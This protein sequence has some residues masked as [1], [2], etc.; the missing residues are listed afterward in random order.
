M[1]TLNKPIKL[2]VLA[3]VAHPDD[4]E[5][6][7]G[8]L[9]IKLSSNKRRVGI[10]DLSYGEMGTLGSKEERAREAL[11][12]AHILGL[13]FRGNL[14]LPDAAIEYNHQNSYR[15]AEQIRFLKPKLVIL[16]HWQ[17]RHPDHLAASKIGY[18]ACFFAGLK[19]LPIKGDAFRPE[20]IIYASY[21]QSHDY[22]F[23]V[24]I[25][26]FIR[27]K[28]KAIACY[29]TQ[30]GNFENYKEL[31]YVQGKKIFDLLRIRAA[32]FGSRVG[33]EFAEAYSIHEDILID[34]PFL[35]PVKSL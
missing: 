33:V 24:D 15:L 20:K 8:G 35:M 7:C 23:L 13:S 5:I 34:D 14:E 4:A 16:P 18:D 11:A 12:S 22:S 32:Y 29:Q 1:Q 17:Q 28:E 30:F 19:K 25:S 9:L 3:V 6:T 27:E 2:D 21:N 31:F 10:I 26:N